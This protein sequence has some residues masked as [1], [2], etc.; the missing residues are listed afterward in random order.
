MSLHPAYRKSELVVVGCASAMVLTL[1][2][3]F[4]PPV[5]ADNAP[6]HSEFVQSHE[7]SDSGAA[8]HVAAASDDKA[9]PDKSPAIKSTDTSAVPNGAGTNTEAKKDDPGA[10]AQAPITGFHPIKKAMRPVENL[11]GLSVKLEQQIIKLQGP[12]LA[13]QSPMAS[14]RNEMDTVDGGLDGMQSQ[15]YAMRDKVRGVRSDLRDLRSE[16][17]DLRGPVRALE[18]P[19]ASVSRP[20]LAVNTKLTYILMSVIAAAV[21]IAFGTP[22]VAYLLFRP[23]LQPSGPSHS[24]S[25]GQHDVSESVA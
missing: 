5:R 20:M 12:L 4:C 22:F 25:A 14:L 21:A 3:S 10:P 15:L 1:Y 13:L 17:K 11:E 16:I 18:K 24:H 7:T 2:S 8:P 23:H 9:S 19:I 6:K